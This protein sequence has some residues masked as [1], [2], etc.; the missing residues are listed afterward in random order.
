VLEAKVDL[1]LQRPS[2]YGSD[3]EVTITHLKLST[4]QL[5][6]RRLQGG[7][8]LVVWFLISAWSARGPDEQTR[9]FEDVLLDQFLLFRPMADGFVQLVD[10]LWV[11]SRLSSRLWSLGGCVSYPL[12]KSG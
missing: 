1:V 2:V 12:M 7:G 6:F 11:K 8:N 4:L 9:T 3:P 10:R 5:F